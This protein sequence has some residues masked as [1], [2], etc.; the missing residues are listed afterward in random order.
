MIIHGTH[1]IIYTSIFHSLFYQRCCNEMYCHSHRVM[2][3]QLLL[4]I[5]LFY[6]FISP[7]AIHISIF[8][9]LSLFVHTKSYCELI[10]LSLS[11]ACMCYGFNIFITWSQNCCAFLHINLHG[12]TLNSLWKIESNEKSFFSYFIFEQLIS[13]SIV[14]KDR[15]E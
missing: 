2:N 15:T 5:V 13:A 10:K 3:F 1:I 14:R 9:L 6:C 8:F 7:S 12:N 11:S 4:L